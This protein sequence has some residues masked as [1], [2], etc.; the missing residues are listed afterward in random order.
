MRGRDAEEATEARRGAVDQQVRGRRSRCR[1]TTSVTT[2]QTRRTTCNPR[3]YPT[4]VC[5]A[6]RCAK[7]ECF[8]CASRV[9]VIFE[10]RVRAEAGAKRECARCKNAKCEYSS[11]RAGVREPRGRSSGEGV[12]HVAGA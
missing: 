1:K 5:S 2:S 3:I 11:E 6:A 10:V 8:E 9:R 12:V 4:R 7:R